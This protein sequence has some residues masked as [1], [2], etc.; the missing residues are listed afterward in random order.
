MCFTNYF[1]SEI[2][3]SEV[4]FQ[5]IEMSALWSDPALIEITYK[6]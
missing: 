1:V 4:I 6:S 5:L 2:I 3:G